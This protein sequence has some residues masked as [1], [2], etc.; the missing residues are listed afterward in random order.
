MNAS[1]QR[2]APVISMP[3]FLSAACPVAW[4]PRAQRT[5]V[6]PPSSWKSITTVTPLPSGQ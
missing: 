2:A 5:M 6:V 4:S 3:A 1:P